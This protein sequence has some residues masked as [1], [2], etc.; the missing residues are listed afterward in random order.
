M[1]Y[2]VDYMMPD[3]IRGQK[4]VEAYDNIAA[5]EKVKEEIPEAKITSVTWIGNQI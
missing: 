4:V 2:T 3:G 1:Q 5:S